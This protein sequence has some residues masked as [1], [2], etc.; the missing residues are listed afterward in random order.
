M[1]TNHT[2]GLLVSVVAL[3][4]AIGPLASG[5]EWTDAS[6][7]FKVEA[8]LVAVRNGKAILEKPDGSVISVPVDKLSAAD[9]EF[10]KSREA[11]APA[12]KTAPVV[13]ATPNPFADPTASV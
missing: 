5:R 6:G 2:F 4:L 3:G 7:K 9:Q 10:L 1:R 13:P 12:A 8:E 11:P